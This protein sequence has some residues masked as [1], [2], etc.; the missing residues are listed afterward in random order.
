M[1][2]AKLTGHHLVT[3]E[4]ILS[5]PTGHNIEWREA[6]AM[7]AE[8]DAISEESNG[9]Y[10]VR[11]GGEYQVFDRSRGKDL[12]VQQVVDL[13][14]MLQAEGITVASLH[15]SDGEET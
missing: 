9:R 15:E 13:R 12:D 11:L 6:A 7:L 3:A 8:L 5:H 10:V 1:A 2:H 14:R 4:R